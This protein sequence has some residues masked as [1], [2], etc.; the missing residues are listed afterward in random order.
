M[1]KISFA[2][3]RLLKEMYGL[4]KV[5]CTIFIIKMCLNFEK[6]SFNILIRKILLYLTWRVRELKQIGKWALWHITV[7]FNENIKIKHTEI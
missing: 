6:L 7:K 1:I 2:L 5:N 3:Q 4:S